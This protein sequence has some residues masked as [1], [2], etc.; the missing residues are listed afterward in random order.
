MNYELALE[1]CEQ[2]IGS[3][4]EAIEYLRDVREMEDVIGDL[5]YRRNALCEEAEGYRREIDA[6]WKIEMQLLNLEYERDLL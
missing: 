2:E 6:E 5:E 4:D 1:R 3:I